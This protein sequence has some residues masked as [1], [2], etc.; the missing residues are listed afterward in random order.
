MKLTRR[1]KGFQVTETISSH[2]FFEMDFIFH[3]VITAKKLIR[4]FEDI[5]LNLKFELLLK[6]Q[7]QYIGLNILL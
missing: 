3:S 2:F 1:D 5:Y 4:L 6:T 7:F